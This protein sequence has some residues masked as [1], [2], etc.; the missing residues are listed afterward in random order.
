MATPSAR[1]ARRCCGCWPAAR[2]AARVTCCVVPPPRTHPRVP[3]TCT[4]PVRCT[5]VS[6]RAGEV[7]SGALLPP[8]PD[9][10]LA[11]GESVVATAPLYAVVMN[12]CRT[13]ACAARR[14]ACSQ[15]KAGYAQLF[16]SRKDIRGRSVTSAWCVRPLTAHCRCTRPVGRVARGSR[17]R[18]APSCTGPS[19]APLAPRCSSHRRRPASGAI[20]ANAARA[21]AAPLLP[22]GRARACEYLVAHPSLGTA[23]RA[24]H[25]KAKVD[26]VKGRALA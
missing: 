7:R 2:P 16:P 20:T 24:A 23:L 18:S 25:L 15:R 9:P 26:Q 17:G 12:V 4:A 14:P 1:P 13:R 5:C 8:R 19:T 11:S 10:R 6:G 3:R 22:L 21:A